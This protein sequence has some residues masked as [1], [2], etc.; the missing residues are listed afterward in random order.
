MDKILISSIDCAA[1]IGVTPEERTLPQHLSID[2]EF[3]TDARRPAA[4]DSL[5]D[6]IDYAQVAAAVAGICSGR[7]FQL[8][9]TV[10][11][12]IA[13]RILSDFPTPRV[14][15]LV[16]KISPLAAPKAVYVS[17]EIIRP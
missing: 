1:N 11:E 7:D 2:V 15:V 4:S 13:S 9:E 3:S 16:R 6:A 14:R 8:I 12:M 5:K 17:I 10:A